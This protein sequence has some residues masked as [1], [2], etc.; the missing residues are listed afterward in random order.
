MNQINPN[1]W[2]QRFSNYQ[3]DLNEL[4]EAVAQKNLNKLE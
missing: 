4:S 1:R 3:M 2:K